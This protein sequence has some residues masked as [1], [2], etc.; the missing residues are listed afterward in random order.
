MSIR[1]GVASSLHIVDADH[2]ARA[3][4]RQSVVSAIVVEQPDLAFHTSLSNLLWYSV[5]CI[6][7]LPSLTGKNAH[8][9]EHFIQCLSRLKSLSDQGSASLDTNERKLLHHFIEEGTKVADMLRGFLDKNVLGALPDLEIIPQSAGGEI[10]AKATYLQWL[11]VCLS[12]EL[13]I[14]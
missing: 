12:E 2:N 4:T 10:S 9:S 7:S 14:S 8:C 1:H 13:R 3:Q 11:A 5:E 6:N